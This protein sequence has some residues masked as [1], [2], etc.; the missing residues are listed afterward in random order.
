MLD[1]KRDITQI[2][3]I[4]FN[5]TASISGIPFYASR[6]IKFKQGLVN[7]NTSLNKEIRFK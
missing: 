3:M 5:L 7:I 2:E 1:F 6:S 4:D